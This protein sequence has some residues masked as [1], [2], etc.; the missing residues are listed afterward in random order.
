MIETYLVCRERSEA[1]GRMK[2][3]AEQF[4]SKLPDDNAD[5]LNI[6][7]GLVQLQLY[8]SKADGQFQL[9]IKCA[10]EK[11]RARVRAALTRRQG[12]RIAWPPKN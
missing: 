8:E 9:T 7:D 2:S 5:Q 4:G 3:I 10:D 6:N 12:R 11:S 1:V